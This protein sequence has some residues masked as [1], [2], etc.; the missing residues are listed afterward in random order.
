M[1]PTLL[2]LVPVAAALVLWVVPVAREVAGGLA[3]LVALVEV[4]IWVL[5]LLEFDFGD[6][7]LQLSAEREWIGDLGI[8]YHVGFYGWSLWLAGLTTVVCAAAI[9]FG[10][11]A[12]RAPTTGSCSSCWARSWVSSPRRTCSSSTSSSRRC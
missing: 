8:S 7:G 2:V 5:A 10:V 6:D 9:G 11:W 3:L 12:G 1:L 4:G